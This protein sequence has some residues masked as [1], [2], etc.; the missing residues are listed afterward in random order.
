MET[1]DIRKYFRVECKTPICTKIS[2]FKFNNK[3]VT[4]VKV[5]ICGEN[6]SCGGL[7]FL[8][9]LNLPVSDI[10]VIEFK[11]IIEKVSSAFYGYIVRK[12]EVDKG[13]YRYGAQFVNKSCDDEQELFISM[14]NE[15]NKE[16]GIECSAHCSS[17]V[18][19][20]KKYTKK[21]DSRKCIRLKFN[22]NFIAKMKLDKISN[23]SGRGADATISSIFSGI[24]YSLYFS[25]VLS[26]S[27]NSL[28]NNFVLCICLPVSSSLI[29]ASAAIAIIDNPFIKEISFVRLETSFSR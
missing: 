7:E 18:D 23:K 3:I 19:C 26:K 13:I 24:R 4:T 5:N 2:I 29:S 22:N 15:L 10:M 27:V 17:D 16:D 6:I 8:Y 12:E 14:I 1:R 25:L 11:L 20:T 21:P 28:T 9:S